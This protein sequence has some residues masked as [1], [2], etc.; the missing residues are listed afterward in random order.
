[1]TRRT[2]PPDD[3]QFDLLGATD[4]APT[5]SPSGPA[6]GS[7][8]RGETNDMELIHTV[9][10]TAMRG[11]YVTA[12]VTERA[13]ALTD[14]PDGETVARLPRFEEDTVHQLL[15]RGWL[16]VGTGSK[17]VRCGA[18][19]FAAAKLLVPKHARTAVTRWSSLARPTTWPTGSAAAHATT[20]KRTAAQ[21]VCP[22]CGEPVRHAPPDRWDPERH[23]RRPEFSHRSNGTPLCDVSARV[24][25]GPY[26]GSY[27][28]A[29]PVS[30]DT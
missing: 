22:I 23:G 18:S 4:P 20:A 30:R 16:R 29:T 1:M 24:N 25:G 5:T 13:Y 3:G 15:A 10:T 9:V 17:H 27:R 7:S 11:L 12:G 2:A 21:L 28:P 8:D 26:R 14:G 19:R 6:A